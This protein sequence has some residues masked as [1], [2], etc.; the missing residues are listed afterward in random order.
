[1][2]PLPFSELQAALKSFGDGGADAMC[3]RRQTRLPCARARL[4]LCVARSLTPRLAPPPLCLRRFGFSD[5]LV[6]LFRRAPLC[7]SVRPTG[8]ANASRAAALRQRAVPMSALPKDAGAHPLKILLHDLC[9]AVAREQL[10][11][12]DLAG[13]LCNA[14]QLPLAV[15]PLLQSNLADVFWFVGLELEVDGGKLQAKEGQNVVALI[16]ALINKEVLDGEGLLTRLE[17]NV[18][19]EVGLIS[20]ETDFQKQSVRVMTRPCPRTLSAASASAASASA[21]ASP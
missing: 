8:S 9:R 5:A 12:D 13:L 4:R 19:H 21:S 2:Q 14:E 7:G 17:P 6:C 20:S 11:P 10:K 16:K 15:R 3:A 1:M 18:L